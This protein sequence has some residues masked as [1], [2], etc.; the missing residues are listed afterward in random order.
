MIARVFGL[1]LTHVITDDGVTQCG[2]RVVESWPATGVAT[3]AQCE[4]QPMLDNGDVAGAADVVLNMPRTSDKQIASSITSA[5]AD[6]IAARLA[7]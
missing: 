1:R 7:A 4:T 2:E 6:V 5:L 3:C